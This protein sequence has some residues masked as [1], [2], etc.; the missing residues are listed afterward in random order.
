MVRIKVHPANVTDKKT[1]SKHWKPGIFVFVSRGHKNRKQHEFWNSL[2]VSNEKTTQ[3][4]LD[5]FADVAPKVDLSP[6]RSTLLALSF[7]PSNKHE[8]NQYLT[9]TIGNRN[10][11][12]LEVFWDGNNAL[13]RSTDHRARITSLTGLNASSTCALPVVCWWIFSGSVSLQAAFHT[14]SFSFSLIFYFEKL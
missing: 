3:K 2:I 8:S 12:E 6:K 1:W 4:N 9:K 5:F 10:V 11:F 7:F 13:R 14:S